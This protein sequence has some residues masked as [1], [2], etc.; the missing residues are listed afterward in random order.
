MARYRFYMNDGEIFNVVEDGPYIQLDDL[1]GAEW[2]E[3]HVPLKIPYSDKQKTV[4]LNVSQ[5]NRI[6][7]IE[8]DKNDSAPS[9]TE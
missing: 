7:V 1:V 5:I 4:F 6:E 9:E 3:I 2:M 8:D